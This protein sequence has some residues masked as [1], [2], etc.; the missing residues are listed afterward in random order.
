MFS[1]HSQLV[2]D[3]TGDDSTDSE[4]FI[5]AHLET[6]RWAP[7]QDYED[8]SLGELRPGPRRVSFTGRVVNLYDQNIENYMPKAAK[9]CLKI[10]VE[11]ERAIILVRLLTGHFFLAVRLIVLLGQ[12]LVCRLVLR[13]LPGL[14]C[15]SVH[16]TY[17]LYIY[18]Q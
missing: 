4:Q 3:L 18:A 7:Q 14:P 16:H 1:S 10:L 2:V 15:H 17:L 5:P 6:S 8:L 12:A 13:P 11:D 9:G